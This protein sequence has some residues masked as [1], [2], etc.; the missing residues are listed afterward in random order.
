[1]PVRYDYEISTD[2]SDT[3]VT[4]AFASSLAVTVQQTGR[5]NSTQHSLLNTSAVL[6]GFAVLEVSLGATQAS[7]LV[8]VVMC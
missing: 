4:G 5:L 7:V 1:M 8:H 2:F 6:S 3:H